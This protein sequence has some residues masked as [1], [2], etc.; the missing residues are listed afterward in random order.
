MGNAPDG[1]QSTLKAV[2]VDETVA[3]MME[4]TRMRKVAFVSHVPLN[5][6][7]RE[8]E[9]PSCAKEKMARTTAWS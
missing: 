8:I 9:R 4:S 2:D 7:P 5:S 1:R 3:S 6:R